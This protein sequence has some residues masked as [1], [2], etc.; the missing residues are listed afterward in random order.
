MSSQRFVFL[1]MKVLDTKT[2][3]ST[4]LTSKM[5]TY[6]TLISVK[7]ESQIKFGG[8]TTL[9]SRSIKKKHSLSFPDISIQQLSDS[10]SHSNHIVCDVFNQLAFDVRRLFQYFSALVLIETI[11]KN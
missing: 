10:R 3:E 1:N 5:S 4:V 2:F 7:K 9:L 11:Q 6:L 8:D